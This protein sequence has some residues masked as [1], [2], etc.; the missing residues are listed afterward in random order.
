MQAL[1]LRHATLPLSCRVGEFASLQDFL[2]RYPDPAKQR[3]LIT[4]FLTSAHRQITSAP[5]SI[6]QLCKWAPW[7]EAQESAPAPAPVTRTSGNKAA[8][9]EAIRLIRS[10]GLR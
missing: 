8:A 6:G 4:G 7:L 9:E 2:A 3:W 5:V 1:A 10:G